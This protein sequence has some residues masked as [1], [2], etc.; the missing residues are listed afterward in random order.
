MRRTRT[1]QSVLAVVLFA[2]GCHSAEPEPAPPAASRESE[3]LELKDK[4]QLAMRENRWNDA[5]AAAKQ[6]DELCKDETV[7]QAV[8]VDELLA[9]TVK[10]RDQHFQHEVAIDFYRRMAALIGA[11][12]REK[13][14]TA[15]LAAARD[16]AS[17][18]LP[19]ELWRS[20]SANEGLTNDE[21]AN[22]WTT[23]TVKSV[24]KATYGPGS[25]IVAERPQPDVPA[26]AR[27]RWTPEEWW[28][29]APSL[30]RSTWL[31]AY[32]VETSGSFELLRREQTDCGGCRGIGTI[33]VIAT[34][35]EPL[36]C[37]EC[38]G[39]GKI[40]SVSYR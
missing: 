1:L 14:A 29:S 2:A 33:Q 38:N 30:D 17:K 15:T 26:A 27:Q 13:S 23:R 24:R 35:N 5:L 28:N 39:S 6:T 4:V 25:F 7:R 18:E 21:V 11:K 12:A 40:R 9:K 16:W 32:F 22:Y 34:D 37:A 31:T 19:A 3:A 20:V 10:G 36:I 8:G